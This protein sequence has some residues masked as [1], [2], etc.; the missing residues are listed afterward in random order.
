MFWLFTIWV[1]RLDV[2][3]PNSRTRAKFAVQGLMDL[4]KS[5]ESEQLYCIRAGSTVSKPN[6][7]TRAKLWAELAESKPDVSRKLFLENGLYVLKVAPVKRNELLPGPLIQKL[8]LALSREIVLLLHPPVFNVEIKLRQIEIW[9]NRHIA[10]DPVPLVVHILNP[11]ARQPVADPLLPARLHGNI[12]RRPK[13][14]RRCDVR[15]EIP[16][17]ENPL[18]KTMTAVGLPVP[19]YP[20]RRLLLRDRPSAPCTPV[21]PARLG[22]PDHHLRRRRAVVRRRAHVIG[23]RCV[24][25]DVLDVRDHLVRHPDAHLKRP[26][27][28][29]KN[30]FPRLPRRGHVKW[31]AERLPQVAGNRHQLPSGARGGAPDRR[32][33]IRKQRD[34]LGPGG[35]PA[36][37]ADFNGPLPLC[38]ADRHR[39]F[40]GNDV[41]LAAEGA[42]RAGMDGCSAVRTLPL[43]YLAAERAVP[44]AHRVGRLAVLNLQ[45][46]ALDRFLHEGDVRSDA[47]VSAGEDLRE[48]SAVIGQYQCQSVQL[49][50]QPDRSLP[51]PF[52]Q[53]FHLFG[54]W[55]FINVNLDMKIQKI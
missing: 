51:R 26:E 49:P 47:A 40:H 54:L 46:E 36:F 7:R 25:R 32:R 42:Y 24:A 27:L 48:S 8:L 20:R 23:M 18:V 33:R 12:I 44:A 19:L 22:F 34:D 13:P 15:L 55:D 38:L 37:A 11:L 35:S 16:L 2:S 21:L 3:K 4:T 10:G 5:T 29:L 30:L 39:L 43:E 6:S 50:A 45:G 31:N 9:P 52:L 28:V 53:F 41:W 1:K 14:F 17:L